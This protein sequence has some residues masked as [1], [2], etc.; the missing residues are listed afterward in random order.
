MNL[1][2]TPTDPSLSNYPV[3]PQGPPGNASVATEVAP[4]ASP[5]M[6]DF[7]AI[8]QERKTAQQRRTNLLRAG[9]FL[10]AFLVPIG[11]LVG[12]G[13]FSLAVFGIHPRSRFRAALS[14]KEAAKSK[15]LTAD[16]SKKAIAAALPTP[17]PAP[18]RNPALARDLDTYLKQGIVP[19]AGEE[20]AADAA[21]ASVTGK[22]YKSREQTIKVVTEQ[23]IPHYRQFVIK[24]YAIH[25]QTPEVKYL[26]ELLQTSARLKLLGYLHMAEDGQDPQELW[27]YAVKAEF[28]EAQ[29]RADEFRQ[30]VSA[31]AFQQ[32]VKLP[33]L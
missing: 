11:Y 26:H 16:E 19:I 3:D 9:A 13:N 21:F 4:G 32:G 24:L 22:N 10:A 33:T 5:H 8:E 2:D 6:V 7:G 28:E 31:L 20:K 18:V 14:G 15:P 17:T 12:T 1:S 30:K 25:P 23:V 27:Q 29:K